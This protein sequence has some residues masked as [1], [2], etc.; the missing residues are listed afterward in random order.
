MCL[1]SLWRVVL[2]IP[3]KKGQRLTTL[4]LFTTDTVLSKMTTIMDNQY[5]R[6]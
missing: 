3:K 2:G 5:K 4:R 1:N 6:Q